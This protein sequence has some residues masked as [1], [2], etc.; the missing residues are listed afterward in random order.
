[1]SKIVCTLI[2][3]GTLNVVSSIAMDTSDM[4]PSSNIEDARKLELQSAYA[5]GYMKGVRDTH[6]SLSG[7][8]LP[9]C[10]QYEQYSH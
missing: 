2:L 3:V 9:M 6:S 5:C 4:R 1:M 7:R 8:T 10:D